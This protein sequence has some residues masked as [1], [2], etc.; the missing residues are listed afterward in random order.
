[1][2]YQLIFND[3]LNFGHIL[4]TRE[5]E[6]EN[7]NEKITEEYDFHLLKKYSEHTWVKDQIKKKNLS[8]KYRSRK[9]C[10]YC[11]FDASY[12]C[13]ICSKL[14][15]PDNMEFIMCCNPFDTERK[16]YTWQKAKA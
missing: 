3:E 2:S 14:D 12:Y 9:A 11:R 13:S 15:D 8:E 16:Q 7:A 6:E 5:N 10:S 4:R 1:M